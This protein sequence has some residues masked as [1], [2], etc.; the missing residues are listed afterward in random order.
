MQEPFFTFTDPD[1]EKLE[2]LYNYSFGYPTVCVIID[3]PESDNE[4]GIN[5]VQYC[6]V[7]MTVE[8]T[9]SLI[10]ALQRV[11]QKIKQD[12]KE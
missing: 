9:E 8:Q 6:A 4:V 2:I 11:I 10:D 1:N 3:E 12:Q 5:P 7:R